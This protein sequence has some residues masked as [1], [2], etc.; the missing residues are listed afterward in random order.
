MTPQVWN[1][2]THVILGVKYMYTLDSSTTP[3]PPPLGMEHADT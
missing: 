3:P 2:M 1:M